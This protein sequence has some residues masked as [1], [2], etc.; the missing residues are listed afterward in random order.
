MSRLVFR[1]VALAVVVT[2]FFA[3][4]D[5][6]DGFVSPAG[7]GFEPDAGDASPQSCGGVKCSRDLHSVVDGCTGEAVQTCQPDQG[8]GNGKCVTACEAAAASLG[9][10]GC[11]FTTTPPDTLRQLDSSCFAA[12][13]ANTWST[14]ATLTATYGTSPLDL[15]K[16]VYRAIPSPTDYTQISY[17]RID[18]PIPPGEVAI[19]FLEQADPAPDVTPDLNPIACPKEVTEA[20]HANATKGHE[21]GIYNAFHLETDVPVSAY[22]IF[23]YGGAKSFIT[24]ATL[25][26]PLS[27]WG[28][29]YVM[30]DALPPLVGNG[31]PFIQL[32]SQEDDTVIRIKPTAELSVGDGVAPALPGAVT[33]YTLQKGQVLEI[34]QSLSLDGSVLESDKPV[35]MFAGAQCTDIPADTEACDLLHQQIPPLNQWGSSYSAVP[36]TTRRD[37][38]QGQPPLPES[39]L[40]MI[41]AA[42]DGT[43]LTYDPEPSG[44]AT[45]PTMGGA[46]PPNPIPHTLSAGQVV[47]FYSDHPFHVRSQGN[48]YPIYVAN[49]MTGA[50]WYYTDGD[51]DFVNVVPDGQFLSDYVFFVD[52]TYRTSTLTFVRQ[53][54]G[55]GF[56]DV[57]L[58]CL[59]PVTS[60]TPLG[61][62]GTI[63]YA[64]VD[65]TRHGLPNGKCT[66]GRHEA[67]S[68]GPFGLYVWGIDNAV[69]YG[70]PAGA[71]SRPTSPYQVV[72]K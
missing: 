48:D 38:F 56:K 11:S 29:N 19:V 72:V 17:Q 43:V 31:K 28:T 70:Y 13:I 68:D 20:L 54:D 12:F 60:W 33:S 18:G 5:N 71:G 4:G 7:G 47:S 64:W 15:S 6:R 67:T 1:F 3:C 27:S 10:I 55:H 26:L 34:L 21:T 24:G 22:S 44:S 14:P 35:A 37:P 62:D 66:T 61:S 59:G 2:S 9:S 36:Y 52:H 39:V 30:F 25:L 51:P 63:E 57:N 40:W 53:N 23:P 50:L 46:A 41:A 45:P 8:C 58:D 69:S 16:S 32:V 65:I 42:R 49:Y